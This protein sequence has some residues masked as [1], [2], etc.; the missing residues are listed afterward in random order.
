MKLAK[1]QTVLV[2]VEPPIC[3]ML[4]KWDHSSPQGSGRNM[5]KVNNV[6]N[7]RLVVLVV[8]LISPCQA[9][10]PPMRFPSRI[11]TPWLRGTAEKCGGDTPKFEEILLEIFS[12]VR[13]FFQKMPILSKSLKTKIN[14]DVCE[15]ATTIKKNNL[16]IL[17]ATRSSA[18]ACEWLLGW[19]TIFFGFFGGWVFRLREN[20]EPSCRN[21]MLR[22]GWIFRQTRLYCRKM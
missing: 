10:W 20:F 11:Q 14:E 1:C 16:S 4:V 21:W 8:L 7:H 15:G 3:N 13:E 6:W 19:E 5:V 17:K 9:K 18:R 2:V 12:I 22:V